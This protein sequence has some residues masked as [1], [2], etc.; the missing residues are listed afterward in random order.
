MVQGRILRTTQTRK[1]Y[2]YHDIIRIDMTVIKKVQQ[3]E[4]LGILT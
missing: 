3:N 1:E 2:L 4:S